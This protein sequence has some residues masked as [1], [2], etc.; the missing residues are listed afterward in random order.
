MRKVVISANDVVK[1][2]VDKVGCISQVRL[3]QLLYYCQAWSLVWDDKPLFHEA[4]KAWHNP[5]ICVLWK[6]GIYNSTFDEWHS[7]DSSKLNSAQTETIDSVIN[8]YNAMSA[9]EMVDLIHS[10]GP[11]KSARKHL[12]LNERGDVEIT[13]KSMK[14]YY[15]RLHEQYSPL[16]YDLLI[17]KVKEI[18]STNSVPKDFEDSLESIPNISESTT[19]SLI[20]PVKLVEILN[21]FAE[22]EGISVDVL[23]K[24]WVDDGLKKWRNKKMEEE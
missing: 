14:N 9:Q 15:G 1:Y 4:I 21:I 20:F 22:R 5:I 11:L 6:S 19:I 10:E 8:Y 17:D 3:H 2:I 12:R 13:H 18:E 7:G 23:I 24:N 16:D